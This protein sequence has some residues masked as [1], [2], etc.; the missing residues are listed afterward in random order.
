MVTEKSTDTPF[1]SNIG[2]ILF[3]TGI[4]LLNFLSR[5]ILAPLMPSIEND[6]GIS[7]GEA[8][9]LFMWISIGYSSALLGSS[10]LSSMVTHRTTIISSS[11]VTGIALVGIAMSRSLTHLHLGLLFLGLAAGIYLPSG[12]ATITVLTDRKHWGKAIAIHELAPSLA[13]IAAPFISEACLNYCSW[14]GVLFIIG[15]VSILA[16]LS[17]TFFGRGGSFRGGI[18]NY[19]NISILLSRHTFWIM[20]VLFSLGIAAGI[21]IYSMLP[22]YLVAERGLERS[23]ANTLIAF[24]RIPVLFVALIA[25]W[26]TDR[27]GPYITMKIVLVFNGIMTVLL[28]TMPGNWVFVIVFLQPMLSVCFFPAAFTVLS[29]IGPPHLR[30]LTI[31]ITV[32]V[33]YL[34]GA[35]FIPALMGTLGETQSFALAIILTGCLIFI[36]VF[37]TRA[38]KSIER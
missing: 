34:V 14:R 13:F 27:I 11:I 31:S 10:K 36:S 37:L 32:F 26:V 3:I 4:F 20:T 24:S 9:I 16:G 19:K 25:G 6:L 33:A 1:I 22:L 17:Y 8:G 12:I 38:L 21:G 7:H 28:G 2:P 5:I 29:Q 23:L 35:G 18:P 15:T 30:N